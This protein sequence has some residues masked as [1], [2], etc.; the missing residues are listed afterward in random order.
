MLALKKLVNPNGYIIFEVPDCTR[1]FEKL[2]YTTIWEE[3]ILYFTDNTF[4]M[5]LNH[6]GFAPHYFEQYNYPFESV[7]IGIVKPNNIQSTS[8][9]LQM[10]KHNIKF[11][12]RFRTIF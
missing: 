4:K 2:D 11:Q 6:G 7:L 10:D 1:G 8:K 12:A 3:H 5:C 9:S